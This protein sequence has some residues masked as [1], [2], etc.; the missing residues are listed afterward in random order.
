MESKRWEEKEKEVFLKEYNHELFDAMKYFVDVCCEVNMETGIAYMLYHRLRPEQ[1][2]KQFYYEDLIAEY[3]INEVAHCDREKWKQ[4]FS[5]ES[6]KKLKDQKVVDIKFLSNHC[7]PETHRITVVGANPL[8][9]KGN[10][11]YISS[12]NIENDKRLIEEMQGEKTGIFAAM[13]V[14]Y[15]SV[16]YV[17][18][19]KD[20]YVSYRDEA[21]T[22][23]TIAKKGSYDSFLED[24]LRAIMPEYRKEFEK[25]FIRAE[26]INR[27]VNGEKKVEME[28]Q[29][30]FPDGVHWVFSR[31]VQVENKDTEDIMAVILAC[32]IDEQRKKDDYLKQE[33]QN[34]YE[35]AQKASYEKTDFL[36]SMS[37]DLC[38]P[39]EELGDI[40]VETEKYLYQPEEIKRQL[41]YMQQATD[42]LLGLLKDVTLMSKLDNGKEHF[43]KTSFDIIQ[44]FRGCEE[45]T[46]TRMPPHQF[47]IACEMEGDISHRK[48]IG[49]PLQLHQTLL[50]IISYIAHRD[51]DFSHTTTCVM[52]ELVE[53]IDRV[54]IRFDMENP[55]VILPENMKQ[56]V[57]DPFAKEYLWN[58]NHFMESGLSMAIAKEMIERLG[59]TIELVQGKYGGTCFRVTIS[60]EK[61]ETDA[62][63]QKSS[64]DLKSMG[65]RWKGKQILIAEE[66]EL[67][68]EVAKMLWKELGATVFVAKN[69]EECVA[70]YESL[71]IGTLDYI[72]VSLSM[73]DYNGFET[74][75]KI[76]S[77]K[78]LDSNEV[79]IVALS[80][81]GNQGDLLAAKAAG[82]NDY[83]VKPFDDKKIKKLK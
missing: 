34:S 59:G 69:G 58:R 70:V 19:T 81:D 51:D 12:K 25:K 65:M 41:N 35:L 73:S 3:E 4:E 46:Q 33:I 37:H 36:L 28:Y 39:L 26:L 79:K 16:V 80:S 60:F 23:D 61:D 55:G 45:L 68:C 7:V 77:S 62:T 75:K 20:Q 78:R 52:T 67:H 43:E 2:E 24:S 22:L 27:F 8:S 48:L 66:N 54:T 49:C 72:F 38:A 5:L 57:F 83:M 82:M 32:T 64:M 15:P 9:K 50:N 11:V 18:L 1:Q 42:H 63:E 44:V 17:N 29:Y 31:V 30:R 13:S 40:I 71:P 76:R 74:A 6:L 47:K 53:T 14:T 56:S 10:R 21:E